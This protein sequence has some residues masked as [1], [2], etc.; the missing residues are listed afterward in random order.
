MPDLPGMRI[1]FHVNC[2]NL[3]AAA[4]RA[5]CQSLTAGSDVYQCDSSLARAFIRSLSQDFLLHLSQATVVRRLELSI[6]LTEQ[7]AKL[8][9]APGQWVR[10]VMVNERANRVVLFVSTENK[11]A[12]HMK[13]KENEF[14]N[15]Y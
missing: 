6:M 7:T 9:R 2:T 3:V 10:E 1:S 12:I 15:E 11:P 13:E 8:G 5:G 14:R 4:D